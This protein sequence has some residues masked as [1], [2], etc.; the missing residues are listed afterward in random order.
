MS[1]GTRILVCILSFGF[2]LR[3][4]PERSHRLRFNCQNDMYL[5]V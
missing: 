2:S 1:H 4:R 3:L 5:L